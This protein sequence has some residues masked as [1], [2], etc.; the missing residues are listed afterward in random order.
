MSSAPQKI[1]PELRLLTTKSGE[2]ALSKLV[3]GDIQILYVITFGSCPVC[4]AK[5]TVKPFVSN[6][7]YQVIKFGSGN[8]AQNKIAQTVERLPTLVQMSHWDQS[9]WSKEWDSRI[10][11]NVMYRL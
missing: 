4:L 6:I 10:S 3:L 8:T 2:M 9:K 5:Q 11:P 1:S 7:H